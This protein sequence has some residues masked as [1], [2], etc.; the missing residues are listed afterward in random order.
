MS[1]GAREVVAVAWQ[2]LRAERLAE[3]VADEVA[4]ALEVNG[5][6]L[7]VMM[8]TPLDLEDFALGFLLSEG[9]IDEPGELLEIEPK[10]VDAGIALQLQVTQRQLHRFKERRRSMVG[11]TG[12]G[13]CG[14]ESLEQALRPLSRPVGT[15]MVSMEAVL[16][17]MAGLAQAQQL[18][19]L[20][21]ATHAAAWCDLRG[22]ALCVREDVGRH[23]A[24]DKLIGAMARAQVDASQGFIAVTS[25][26]SYEMVHK[27]AMA[28]VGLL[29]AI[30][31]PTHLAIRT[32][33]AAGLT[34]AGFVRGGRATVYTHAQRLQPTG[35]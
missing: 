19:Q 29:A 1:G 4:V 10:P 27:T 6:S 5:L 25:R 33:D 34:L 2:G 28:G 18:Q 26:A 14:A 17:G 9:L 30:S 12:C 11:R 13:I 20:T 3:Q 16:H 8:A 15:A 35:G 23:N 24:L 31:G 32:A 7:A 21:G 22:Q